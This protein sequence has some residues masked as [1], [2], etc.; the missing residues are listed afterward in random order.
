MLFV[1]LLVGCQTGT[2]DKTDTN[3]DDGNIENPEEIW[4]EVQVKAQTFAIDP[5]QTTKVTGE[6]GTYLEFAPNTFAYADG[7]EVKGKITL[8][9]KEYYQKSDMVTSGLTTTSNGKTLKSAGM[10]HLEAKASDGKSLQIKSG[11]DYNIGFPKKGTPDDNMQL[12]YGKREG[13]NMN[14]EPAEKTVGALPQPI[15]RFAQDTLG[16]GVT[17]E[18]LEFYN[19]RAKKMKWI[20]CDAFYNTPDDQITQ[21]KVVPDKMN[22][23]AT[24]IFYDE[25]IVLRGFVKE[26]G[27]RNF[28]RVLIGKTGVLTVVQ[29][30]K[31]GFYFYA[32]SIKADKAQEIKVK[33]EKT[34]AV[35]AKKK[36]DALLKQPSSKDM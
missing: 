24:I 15:M 5:T 11:K 35:E 16:G 19:F 31:S 21:V 4:A 23:L 13:S 28:P 7:S 6:Q 12:F 2:T 14:W 1:S 29:K 18:M 27:V 36:M 10:V 9:L 26:N 22:A 3:T 20:N 25:S 32:Q 30:D 33:L 17:K 8:N 34:T